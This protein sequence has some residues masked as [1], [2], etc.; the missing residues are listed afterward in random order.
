MRYLPRPLI[1]LSNPKCVDSSF[2]I[3]IVC[4]NSLISASYGYIYMEESYDV[5]SGC[6]FEEKEVCTFN[7]GIVSGVNYILRD[8]FSVKMAPPPQILEEL[9]LLIAK[10]YL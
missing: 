1:E 8:I 5:T 7:C 3:G 2:V 9:S 10:F 4:K 6:H